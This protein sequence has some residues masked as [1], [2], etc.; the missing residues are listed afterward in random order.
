MTQGTHIPMSPDA[1]WFDDVSVL[2]RRPTEF[3]PTAFQTTSER[4]NALVRLVL[5]ASLAAFAYNRTPK[6]LVLGAAVVA[7]VTLVFRSRGR[8]ESFPVT[9]E[10]VVQTPRLRTAGCTAPTR[11]NPFANLLVSDISKNRT[12]ACPYDAVKD[13]IRENF[14]RGLIR[15]VHDVYEVENSQRQWY[16]MPV[17]TGVPDTKAFGE[18]LYGSLNSCKADQTLCVP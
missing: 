4:V 12:E 17:T 6:T 18:F 2:W 10:G 16:T 15:S 7:V 9:H 14:N 1:L 11:D 13:D 8:P 5:Y 3:F